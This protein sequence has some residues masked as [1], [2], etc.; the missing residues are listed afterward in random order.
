MKLTPSSFSS[1]PAST[2]SPLPIIDQ[3]GSTRSSSSSNNLLHNLIKSD[4]IRNNK[5]AILT[6]ENDLSTV[7][8]SIT[9]SSSSSSSGKSMEE[10]PKDEEIE[11]SSKTNSTSASSSTDNDYDSDTNESTTSTDSGSNSISPRVRISEAPLIRSKV[12]YVIDLL[13]PTGSV[14]VLSVNR[15]PPQYQPAFDRS[16]GRS[17]TSL[18]SHITTSLRQQNYIPSHPLQYPRELNNDPVL[19]GKSLSHIINPELPIAIVI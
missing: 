15:M 16:T 12:I 19:T 8:L 13:S 2:V 9:S 1:S 11:D 6:N 14:R 18:T 10:N 7:S 4:E 17:L 3:P 5:N